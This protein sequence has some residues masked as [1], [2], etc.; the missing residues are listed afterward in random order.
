MMVVMLGS[1]IAILALFVWLR[2]V[3][4][5]TFWKISP[6]IVLLL[7]NVLLFIPMGWG[8]PSGPAAVARNSVQI[9]PSVAGEV[10]DVPVAANTPLKAGDML[11][12]IDPTTYQAQLDAIQAQL[13]FAELRLSQMTQLQSR[14]SALSMSSSVRKKSIS[15]GRNLTAPSGISTRQQYA[16]PRMGTSPMWHCAK[17]HASQASPA[18]WRLSIPPTQSSALSCRKCSR[19]TLHPVSQS[20]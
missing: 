9:V 20:R 1:Y 17:V 7:L 18:S 10:I 3:P 16:P 8:A 5:N 14:D 13:K 19:A 6:L 2:F 12:R 4:L 15:S 11:F